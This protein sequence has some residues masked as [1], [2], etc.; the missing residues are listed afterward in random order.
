VSVSA[1]NASDW[2]IS[3]SEVRRRFVV[4]AVLFIYVLSLVEGPL[5]KW[6]LPDLAG[7]LTLLRDPFVIALYVYAFRFGMMLRRGSAALWLGFAAVTS[8]F[9]LLQYMANDYALS[10]WVLGVRTYW[11]YLPLA[12]VVARTFRYEDVLAFLRLNLW[13]A[14]PYALLV[15]TQYNAGPRAFINLGVAGEEDA[16]GLA[17]GILRPFG[18]FTYTGPNVQFTAAMIG[19]FLAM[20]LAGRSVR[21]LLPVF[22]AMA[23]A[24]GTMSVLTGSR[25]IYFQSAIILGYTILGILV[26]Q[27]KSTTLAR[28]LGIL[29]FVGLAALMFVQVFPDMLAAMEMRFERAAAFEGSTSS[30]VFEGFWAAIAAYSTAPLLGHG[31][32]AGAPG[33][34]RFIG[35]PSLIYGESDLARNVNEL[36]LL[37]GTAMLLLRLGLAAWLAV[38]AV[39]L[40]KRGVPMALPMVGFCLPNLIVGQI[41][42]S[43]L[44]A[45]LV[46]LFVGLV[47]AQ[48]DVGLR[49]RR[50]ERK[51]SSW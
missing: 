17:D 20:Y 2:S 10:A 15:A 1:N 22:L 51:C 35:L 47:L 18:L 28:V 8:C 16:V 29:A 27:P 37:L 7:P 19:M 26:A 40:A 24:V 45:F 25:A 48:R 5:R 39:R 14:L 13:I 41:T 9:G 50:G 6:F 46:W 31:I 21:P 23:V 30:R 4:R 11:L 32:G 49:Q 36:G 33:V 3:R 34:A 43:P 38:L 12:F 42:H 44:N